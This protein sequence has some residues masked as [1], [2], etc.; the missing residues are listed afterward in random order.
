[1][2]P[3]DAFDTLDGETGGAPGMEEDE[4]V[5]VG[6][7]EEIVLPGVR[8]N[9]EATIK[10]L[11]AGTIELSA[12]GTINTETFANGSFPLFGFGTEDASSTTLEELSITLGTADTG[13]ATALVGTGSIIQNSVA[14][15]YFPVL[16]VAESV[17]GTGTAVDLGKIF[18][19]YSAGIESEPE[20]NLGWG[21]IDTNATSTIREYVL[22]G[23]PI[24]YDDD[25]HVGLTTKFGVDPTLVPDEVGNIV[26]DA[27]T[28]SFD[29][30]AELI[31]TSYAESEKAF[32]RCPPI[33]IKKKEI[34][35][36]TGTEE[37]E[38]TAV[39]GG[40]SATTST[41]GTY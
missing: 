17:G 38:E 21:D 35:N 18:F 37:A 4:D 27:L 7:P 15:G 32:P 24:N 29:S 33:R 1:M 28:R 40:S 23:E 39:V 6:A 41:G 26:H 16:N 9:Y 36:I 13:T 11:T 10:V 3:P 34:S 25:E 20:I 31:V 5:D 14:L 22:Q 19:H 30:M 12:G 2:S 8:L